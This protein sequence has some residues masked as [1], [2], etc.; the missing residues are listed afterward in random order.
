MDFWMLMNCVMLWMVCGVF[1]WV[2][3]DVG[4]MLD[5]V[6]VCGGVVMM[7]GRMEIVGEDSTA[8]T[9]GDDA[10]EVA[11]DDAFEYVLMVFVGF[12]YV[13]LVCL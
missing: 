8:A 10:E 13:S 12:L 7:L 4:V 9:R 6:D 2:W 3:C 5:G 1:G 11:E